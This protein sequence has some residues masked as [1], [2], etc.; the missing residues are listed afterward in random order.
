M[1]ED[2][3]LDSGALLDED[4]GEFAAVNAALRA[5]LSRRLTIAVLLPRGGDP[6]CDALCAR[7]AT[8]PEVRVLVEDPGPHPDYL[9][10]KA[11]LQ[12]IAHADADA[13]L[14]WTDD[15][16]LGAR[17]SD[18]LP[19][20]AATT[21][22]PRLVLG[23]AEDVNLLDYCFTAPIGPGVTRETA[24]RAGYEGGFPAETLTS[25]LVRALTREALAR[26]QR[27][28]GSSPPCYL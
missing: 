14:V 5:S 22:W 20:Q 13:L 6:A 17:P 4:T 24:R 12:A 21:S 28:H 23:A 10:L 18:G 15:V 9:S 3:L 19:T 16:A 7:L 11:L 25:R 1:R 2:D 26:E 8:Y 27:R